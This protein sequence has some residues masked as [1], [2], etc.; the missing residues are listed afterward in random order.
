MFET[1]PIHLTEL[2]DNVES[3]RIRLPDFQRGWVW[4]DDRIQSLLSSILRGFPVGAIMTLE[5]GG[6]I[7]LQSR[8]VEGVSGPAKKDIAEFLLDGQQRLTSLYQAL[9]HKG[10][11][12]THD[13]RGV[14][15]SRWYYIDMLKVMQSGRNGEDAVKSVPEDK[16]V[17][18]NFGRETELDLRTP[19]YEFAQH[20]IPTECLLEPMEWLFEYVDYWQAPSRTHPCGD[21]VSFRKKFNNEF[22]KPFGQ[23][24]LPV[25]RLNKG[26]PKEAVCTVFEK[27]NTGGVTLTVFELATAAF[28]ADS[29]SFSLRK[30]WNQRRNRLHDQYQYG[31]L[32]GIEGEQFLQAVTLLETQKRRRQAEAKNLP[33]N[34]LPAIGCQKREI[35]DLHVCDYQS[36]A[37]Q[38]EWGFGEAAKFL[39]SHFIFTGRD[40]PYTTQLISL[41]VIFVELGK[42][43]SARYRAKVSQ[44]FWSG[45]FGERYRSSIETQFGLDLVQVP[46]WL[47]GEEMP[48]L[49]SEAN[50]TPE[51]LLSLRTRNS[52]AYKGLYA[53]QMASGAADWRTA[54]KLSFQIWDDARIDIHH[55]FPKAWCQRIQPKIPPR[56]YNS[57][58]NKTPI[59]AHTNRQI[60]GRA[61]SAYLHRLTN[62]ISLEALQEILEAHW[63]NPRHLKADQFSEFFIERGARMMNLIGQA[64]GKN[65][66]DGRSVFAEA[67]SSADL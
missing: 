52:A 48:T 20:M 26:T 16:R 29:E 11:V 39:R 64:M 65:L 53:L 6:E 23:Y 49:V 14:K 57:I 44:W 15:I 38:V 50:F 13:N 2:L 61:P 28:A 47:R 51:R 25:I 7:R 33:A 19:E 5:A 12:R 36:W 27:V 8:L 34:L 59:D 41:A 63:I 42:T 22:L 32:Q 54:E 58:I 24:R 43:M 10:P 21:L 37:D 30:D 45:I 56:L 18:R 17:A 62:D 3:G 4:D 55:V 66:D 67:L 31:V 46:A 40:V 1:H 9:Q 35:L 60:G